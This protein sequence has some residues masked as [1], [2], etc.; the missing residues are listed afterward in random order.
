MLE[1]KDFEQDMRS[2]LSTNNPQMWRKS[3]YSPLL[4]NAILANAVGLLNDPSLNT[5]AIRDQFANQAVNQVHS[6]MQRP[7]ISTIYGLV[8]LA[9]FYGSSSPSELGY[10]YSGLALRCSQSC[11]SVSQ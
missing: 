6:E 1:Q 8:F 5:I 10:M 4:H 9:R 3:Y 11:E 2:C 7:M